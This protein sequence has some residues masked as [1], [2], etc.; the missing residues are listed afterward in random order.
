MIFFSNIQSVRITD[1][2]ENF[3]FIS[4]I[5]L[6]LTACSLNK[7]RDEGCKGCLYL[8][9]FWKLAEVIEYQHYR[10]LW[11]SQQSQ[12]VYATKQDY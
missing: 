3:S 8:K 9:H 6:Q 12:I 4:A 7:L 1:S 10:Y 2:F 11:A 5:D